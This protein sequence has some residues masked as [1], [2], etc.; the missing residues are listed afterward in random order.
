MSSMKGCMALQAGMDLAVK[1]FVEECTLC[2]QCL[3]VCPVFSEPKLELIDKGPAVVMAKV[4]DLLKGGPPSEEAYRMCYGCS[5]GCTNICK[6]ACPKVLDLQPVF[7]A[8]GHRLRAAGE[9]MPPLSFHHTPGHRYGFGHVFGNLQMKESEVPWLKEAPPD[10]EPVDVVLFVSCVAH[11][12]TH[13]VLETMDILKKMQVKFVTVGARDLCC[14]IATFMMGDMADAARV[15][16]KYVSTLARFGAK[17]VVSICSTCSFWGNTMLPSILPVPFA[18]LHITEFLADNMDK[19]SFSQPLNKTV[20]IHDACTQRQMGKWDIARK[21]LKAIPGLTLVEMEHNK[22]KNICCGAMTDT[23]FP[24]VMDAR[25]S[26]RLEEARETG[27]D[28]MTTVCPGCYQV[29]CGY[30]NQYPF[31]IN[32]IISVVAEAMGIHHEDKLKKF[33]LT[34]DHNQVLDEAHDYVE[35]SDLSLLEFRQVLPGYFRKTCGG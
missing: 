29:F 12:L 19:L 5:Y 10:P 23:N 16:E 15:S 31:A 22:E 6:P 17:Q 30:E 7:M 8:L 2:G 32:N 34:G 13:L 11:G 14:G 24:G 27:A 9:G 35:A 33:L 3:E 21:L 20:T 4:V 1:H 28:I 25:Y 18:S 26:A